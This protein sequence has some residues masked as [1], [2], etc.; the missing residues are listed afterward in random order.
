[1]TVVSIVSS[2]RKGGFGDRIAA[3]VEEGARAAG[4]DVVRFNLNDMRSIRQCQ[5]CEA[6]KN[7]G[8]RCIINDDITP[9]VE[10]VRDCEGL[11]IST[12][13]AFNEMNGLFKMV[14]DRFYCF[15]DMN[16][17]TTL[18]KGKKLAT[19]VTAGMDDTRAEAVSKEIEKV[20]H[21]H[22]FFEPVG[23]LTCLTWMMPA[24]SPIDDDLLQ[25]AFDVG[26]CF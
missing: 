14:H 3:K 16:A 7:N 13:I 4:K 24:D 8:G 17:S 6:C 26:S 5:N 1:M 19:I 15:L 10:A 18:P 2:P 21:E 25:E 22:F 20:M 12:N 23:R 9:I 11:I